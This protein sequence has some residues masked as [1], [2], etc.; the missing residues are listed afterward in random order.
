MTFDLWQRRDYGVHESVETTNLVTEFIIPKFTE[1]PTCFERNTAHD[2][3][4]QSVFAASGLYT[5]IK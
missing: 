4:L 5:A 2:Q 1:D 3:E